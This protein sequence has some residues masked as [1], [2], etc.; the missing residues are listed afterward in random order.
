M[1]T[2]TTHR[3]L[4]SLIVLSG[5]SF[6]LYTHLPLISFLPGGSSEMTFQAPCSF[7]L[8][9]FLASL[10]LANGKLHGYSLLLETISALVRFG[11]AL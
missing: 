3:D 2:F 6:F 8:P 5:F 1:N 10:T 7:E 9:E 11:F 4:Y